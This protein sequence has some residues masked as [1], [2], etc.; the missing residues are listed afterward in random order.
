MPAVP[1]TY[2]SCDSGSDNILPTVDVIPEG[3]YSPTSPTPDPDLDDCVQVPGDT[4][5]AVTEVSF[6]IFHSLT[7]ANHYQFCHLQGH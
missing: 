4:L 2:I 5:G 7:K 1:P 3:Q 6:L